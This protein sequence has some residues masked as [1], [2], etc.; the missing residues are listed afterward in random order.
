VFINLEMDPCIPSLLSLSRLCESSSSNSVRTSA[1]VRAWTLL[2]LLLTSALGCYS[3]SCSLPRSD[4][5]WNPALVV[6]SIRLPAIPYSRIPTSLGA[7][8]LSALRVLG[9]PLGRSAQAS[10]RA[11]VSQFILQVR[12]PI[13]GPR[14]DLCP[15]PRYSCIYKSEPT[16]SDPV[17]T[18]ILVRVTIRTLAI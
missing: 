5:T 16:P 4:S 15:H 18:S 17:R 1:H 3:D 7:P 14:L 8:C 9:T 6:L 13:F 2:G 12:A 10:A 11:S